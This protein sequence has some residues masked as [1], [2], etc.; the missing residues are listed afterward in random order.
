MACTTS[1]YTYCL[2]RGYHLHARHIS[3]IGDSS[4]YTYSHKLRTFVINLNQ[5]Q[6]LFDRGNAAYGLL[7]RSYVRA[8]NV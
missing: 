8:E 7:T 5:A 3:Y 6:G 2:G 1:V 4:K